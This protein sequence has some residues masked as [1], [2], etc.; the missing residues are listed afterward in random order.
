[1]LPVIML[2][3]EENSFPIFTDMHGSI[4]LLDPGGEAKLIDGARMTFLLKL[5]NH[6]VLMTWKKHS[7]VMH[8][9]TQ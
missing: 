5:L 7:R 4:N 8:F 2:S 1:M 9:G 3:H 6:P